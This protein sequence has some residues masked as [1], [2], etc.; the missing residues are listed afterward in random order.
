MQPTRDDLSAAFQCELAFD[1]SLLLHELAH[2]TAN[3]L[4][5]ACAEV[6]LAGRHVSPGVSRDRLSTTVGRLQSLAA[7]Q[8]LLLPPRSPEIDLADSLLQLCHY[9][10]H[11]RFVELGACV[12]CRVVDARV[13]SASGWSLLVIVSELLT[14]TARHAF[15]L[16]G[17]MVDVQLTYEG[18]E[19]VCVVHDD[20]VGL[21]LPRGIA[22]RGTAIVEDLARRA[23]F[24]M[25]LPERATGCAFELRLAADLN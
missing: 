22:G 20:G 1:S 14:N 17:G 16:P 11:A 9:Q 6:R 5:V 21:K 18:S 13:P 19:L 25:T 24:K 7:I 15:D 8:R 3:D 4:T 12:R 10:A 2:R 23:G